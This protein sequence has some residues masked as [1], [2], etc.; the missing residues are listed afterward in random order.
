MSCH[1]S[2]CCHAARVPNSLLSVVGQLNALPRSKRCL[3]CGGCCNRGHL[4]S[5]LFPSGVPI[6]FKGERCD[7]NWTLPFFLLPLQVARCSGFCVCS[8]FRTQY[9]CRCTAKSPSCGWKY[10]FHVKDTHTL[11]QR[12][13]PPS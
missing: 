12:C 2:A 8:A 6:G 11:Y 13:L 9:I 1:T 10:Q 3:V 4:L 7:I 5:P